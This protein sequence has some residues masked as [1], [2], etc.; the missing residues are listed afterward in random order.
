MGAQDEWKDILWGGAAERQ[1]AA[2]TDD[3]ISLLASGRPCLK[4]GAEK[5]SHVL[6]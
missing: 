2:I 5:F 6:G 3:N 1:A 4:V